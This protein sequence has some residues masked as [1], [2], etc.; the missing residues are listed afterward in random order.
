MNPSRSEKT[1]GAQRATRATTL[2]QG[3]SR[4]AGPPRLLSWARADKTG[5]KR[6]RTD[7]PK[8]LNRP[9]QPYL[10]SRLSQKQGPDLRGPIGRKG[11][12]GRN[13]AARA[14]AAI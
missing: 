6:A 4:E 8:G 10:R 2:D 12:R 5:Q 7:M 1:R 14:R 9:F 13:L 3:P 11:W